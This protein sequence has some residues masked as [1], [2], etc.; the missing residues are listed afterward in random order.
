MP[1]VN[2][3]CEGCGVCL[4][5]C[6]VDAIEVN[7]GKAIIDNATC[8]RCGDCFETCPL[9]AIRPNSENPNLRGRNN[10]TGRDG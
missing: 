4:E 3:E 5:S 9:D 2:E 1:W 8:T 7:N 10:R 6:P